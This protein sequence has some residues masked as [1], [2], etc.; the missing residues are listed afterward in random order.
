[1]HI[2]VLACVHRSLLL[3]HWQ[4]RKRNSPW[5]AAGMQAVAA[6]KAWAKPT[7]LLAS[8]G[9]T[10]QPTPF[11]RDIR[12]IPAQPSLIDTEADVR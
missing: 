5:V 12:Y 1:M 7:R 10:R 11:V 9:S 3:W 4:E 6:N 8:T 2:Y